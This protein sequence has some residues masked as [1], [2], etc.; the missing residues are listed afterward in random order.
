MAVNKQ[1][2]PLRLLN[3]F[4]WDREARQDAKEED[5]KPTLKRFFVLLYRRFWKLISLNLI[6][7]PTVLPFLFIFLILLGAKQ[8]PTETEPAF[9]VLF[10]I[11]RISATPL[12]SLLLDLFGSQTGIPVYSPWNYILIGALALFLLVTFG[13]QN[14]GAAYVLR[15]MV[16]GDAV[17]V[18]SDYFYAIKKNLKK[19]FFLGLLDLI[20]L[21][22][23]AFDIWYFQGVG[24]T[25]LLDLMFFVIIAISI[26]Y[27]FM[28]FYLYQMEV[29]FEL[30]IGKI[31]KNALI[32]TALGI[33]RNLMAALGIALLTAI[34]VGL[35]FLFFPLNIPIP[36]ILPFFYYVSFVAFISA[37]GAYPVIEKYMIAPY[38]KKEKEEST[39]SE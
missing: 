14:V 35:I 1:R 3:P 36:I 19:G 30:S 23:L 9:S 28:R 2:K 29:T 11:H 15:G 31:F 39:E 37:Y 21:S 8:T 4:R 10:G 7:L 34:D 24:G 5:T 6:M 25:F 26:L 33:K 22:I 17:F 38:Q 27:F 16:R 12:S 32:F 13:W 18:F 20:I